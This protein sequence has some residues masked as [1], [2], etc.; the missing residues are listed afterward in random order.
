MIIDAKG[1]R[2]GATSWG[3][4]DDAGSAFELSPPASAKGKWTE[5]IL[6]SFGASNTDGRYY[7]GALIMDARGN[8]YGTTEG[9]G[10][11]T[12]FKGWHGCGTAFEL[13]PPATTGAKWTEKVL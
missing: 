13:S 3:G 8:P 1:N 9:G 10:T 11:S 6:Y 12:S 4:A 2:Y 5:T 7:P